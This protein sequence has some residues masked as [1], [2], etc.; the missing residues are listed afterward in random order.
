M[1]CGAPVITGQ[2]PALV[3]VAGGAV[4]HVDRLDVE[5]LGEAMVALARDRD[6]RGELSS[7]RARARPVA[8]VAAGGT[9]NAR[10]VSPDRPPDVA[11]GRSGSRIHALK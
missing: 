4:E 8:F 7:P 6:R 3:E 5:S 1:A 2:V 11:R 9:R 10:R